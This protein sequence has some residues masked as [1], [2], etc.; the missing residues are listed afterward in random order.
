MISPLRNRIYRHLFAAQVCQVLGSV[1]KRLVDLTTYK[2]GRP[3]GGGLGS[4][5]A[6]MHE[7]MKNRAAETDE[8]QPYRL[9]H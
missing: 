1:N 8:I 6:P 9:V 5:D 2:P 3:K 7:F 4:L